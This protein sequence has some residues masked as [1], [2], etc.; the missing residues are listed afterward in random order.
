[1]KKNLEAKVSKR[2]FQRKLVKGD[3]GDFIPYCNYRYHPG[4]LKGNWYFLCEKR[5]CHHYKKLKI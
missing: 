2:I 3:D 5:K 4:V 1:M